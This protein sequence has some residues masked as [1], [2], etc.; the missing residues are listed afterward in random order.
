GWA[1]PAAAAGR[2]TAPGRIARAGPGASVRAAGRPARGPAAA[3]NRPAGT[4][5]I[6]RHPPAGGRGTRRR[7]REAARWAP[8]AS[9]AAPGTPR[10]SP[11]VA[12]NSPDRR[13]TAGT[14]EARKS[15]DRRTAVGV[16]V[17]KDPHTTVL[18]GRP[19]PDS[20]PSG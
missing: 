6:A 16:A 12:Q 11:V 15:L 20:R 14:A 1:W 10:K 17:R 8:G 7:R 2:R 9:R 4:G 3:R 13:R 19:L 18:D 5:R